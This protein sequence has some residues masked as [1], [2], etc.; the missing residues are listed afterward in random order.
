MTELPASSHIFDSSDPA[1]YRSGEFWA[2]VVTT[3]KPGVLG[4]VRR[5]LRDGAPDL[6]PV[7]AE[8]VLQESWLTVTTRID[9]E[10][11]A[12]LDTSEA[13]RLVFRGF[14]YTVAFRTAG[15]RMSGWR[16]ECE[17]V[18]TSYD[19]DRIQLPPTVDEQMERDGGLVWRA[20]SREQLRAFVEALTE[21]QRLV[22]YRR[23]I[24]KLTWAQVA[25]L[26][27]TGMSE[28]ALRVM[29]CR[30]KARLRLSAQKVGVLILKEKRS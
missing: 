30:L 17:L 28:Q 25:A 2:V 22:L 10:R 4:F 24:E 21:P 14:L 19:L 13:R 11:I 9:A 27:E 8:D 16:K 3:M 15:R 1:H 29:A 18:S 5:L 6:P 26:D 7:E 23:E 12:A 20:A